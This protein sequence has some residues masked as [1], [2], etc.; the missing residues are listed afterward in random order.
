MIP[1]ETIKTGAA[2]SC[3]DCKTEFK[4]EVMRS[5]AGYYIGTT[6]HKEGC[7]SAGMPNSR[8]SDYKT[9]ELAE[10]DLKRDPEGDTWSR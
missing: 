1:G 2:G 9:E 3:M 7:D 5:A 4:F 10:K 6:C 8:E